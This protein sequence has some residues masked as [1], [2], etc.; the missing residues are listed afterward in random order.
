MRARRPAI[1]ARV[2]LASREDLRQRELYRRGDREIGVGEDLEPRER[3]GRGASR[4]DQPGE[5]ELRQRRVFREPAER[6]HERRARRIAGRGVEQ[7]RRSVARAANA[8]AANTSSETIGR[9]SSASA[10]ASSRETNDPVGLFGF[11]QTTPRTRGSR[12]RAR[13]SAESMCQAPS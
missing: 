5:L 10:R 1:A 13:R 9:P 4:G 7:R 6:E 11:T 8:Y 3:L 2:S 12:A